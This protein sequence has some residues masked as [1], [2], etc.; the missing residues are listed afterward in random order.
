MDPARLVV[1]G[2]GLVS[3]LRL[4]FFAEIER[5][6]VADEFGAGNGAII[7]LARRIIAAVLAD[8]KIDSAMDADG[9]KAD[10]DRLF[11]NLPVAFPTVHRRLSFLIFDLSTIV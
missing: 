11:A 6:P 8:V 9:P 3:D 10:L 1:R 4:E 2:W 5:F 7:R